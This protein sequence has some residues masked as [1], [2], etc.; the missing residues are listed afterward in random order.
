VGLRTLLQKK[1]I[2]ISPDGRQGSQNSSRNT[3]ISVL[4]RTVPIGD[5]AA[6]LAYESR[7][8]TMWF[9]MNRNKGRFAPNLVPGPTREA[10]ESFEQFQGRFNA[11]YERMLNEFFC[12]DPRNLPISQSWLNVFCGPEGDD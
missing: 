9:T 12:G 5:G 2:L 6:F 7:C 4:G 1:A 3:S 11:F 8:A 10:S